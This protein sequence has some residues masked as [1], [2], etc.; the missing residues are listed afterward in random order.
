MVG[1]ESSSMMHQVLA[2]MHLDN[3]VRH[4][5]EM[6]YIHPALNE[7]LLPASVKAV[8]KVKAFLKG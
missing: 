3:D 8:G 2:I 7:A 4:L 6:L 1:P 5:K